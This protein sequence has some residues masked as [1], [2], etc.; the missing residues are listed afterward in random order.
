MTI[1][2][3]TRFFLGRPVRLVPGSPI[4]LEQAHVWHPRQRQLY[5]LAPRGR[6]L[7][8]ADRGLRVD[9]AG[10]KVLKKRLHVRLRIERG[11]GQ[12]ALRQ[13]LVDLLLRLRDRP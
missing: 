1:M 2:R 12:L 8:I 6:R 4:L 9:V 10:T 7:A 5:A 13:E 3:P 11:M